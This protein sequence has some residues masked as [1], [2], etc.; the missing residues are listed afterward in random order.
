M[1][2][3]II[4]ICLVITIILV[5]IGL[6]LNYKIKKD[7]N[8]LYKKIEIFINRYYKIIVVILFILALFTS[9]YQLGIIPYGMHVDEAGMAYDALSLS[10]YGVDRYLNKFPVYL[11]NYGGGQSA[12][13][14]Y[15]AAIL[16]KIFGYSIYVVRMPAIIL[17]MLLVIGGFIMVKDSKDKMQG[18][19]ILFLLA[20]APYFI[21]QSRWGLDCN[22]LVG[23]LTIA[24]TFLVKAINKNSTKLLI[25]SGILFGLSLYTYALS[26]IILPLLLLIIVIYLWY[27]KKIDLKKLIAFGIPIFLFAIPLMLMIL[28]N[29]GFIGQIKGII[30]I[31]LLNNY[32]GG[33]ISPLNIFQNLYIFKTVLTY[34]STYVFGNSLVYNALPIFGTLYYMT[35]PFIILGLGYCISSFRKSLKEKQFSLDALM[36]MW[37]SSVII[38][39]LLIVYPNINKANA[40]FFPLAYFALQGIIYTIKNYKN[41][42]IPI[43]IMLLIN[44]G[45]F[46]NYYFNQYNTDYMDQSY[47]ATTYLDALAY[48]RSLGKENIY[49]EDNLASQEY[50]YPL[51]ENAVSPY[52]YNNKVIHTIYNKNN[53]IYTIGIPSNLNSKAVYIVRNNSLKIRDLFNLGFKE[54]EFGKIV[55]FSNK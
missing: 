6:F 28:V 38:C 45:L 27:L 22:L 29:N 39:Q 17:R 3:I 50:I 41:M 7:N 5:G 16:I 13:Y 23:F 4:N 10:K 42:I 53:I 8:K 9:L 21:M 52:E 47:F 20:I 11:I 1:M 25:I 2:S 26:Y 51:L 12:M 19:L 31:P 46:F 30:T 14:A 32:R 18:L 49:I 15:L 48:S 55:V 43:I 40:I 36:L 24:F 33:E 54:K 44:F 35:I 34:D 37:F